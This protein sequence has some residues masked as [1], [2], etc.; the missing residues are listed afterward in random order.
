MQWRTQKLPRAGVGGGVFTTALHILL[1]NSLAS[2]KL[3][4]VMDL[5]DG[6]PVHGPRSLGLGSA[7]GLVVMLSWLNAVFHGRKS[8]FI[9]T[10]LF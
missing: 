5:A 2:N 1:T 6:E 8:L 3:W 7:P 10:D 9:G 4:L